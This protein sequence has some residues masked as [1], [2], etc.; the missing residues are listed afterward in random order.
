MAIYTG[1]SST[2]NPTPVPRRKYT[3]IA[4]ARENYSALPELNSWTISTFLEA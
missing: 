2:S 3:I 1:A 4:R